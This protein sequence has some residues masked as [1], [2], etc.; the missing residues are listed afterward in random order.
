MERIERRLRRED[1]GPADF[2]VFDFDPWGNRYPP[3]S[4]DCGTWGTWDRTCSA[5]GRRVVVVALVSEPLLPGLC[6]RCVVLAAEG[7]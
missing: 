4:P 7:R 1:L 5:C 2:V 6:N 3:D